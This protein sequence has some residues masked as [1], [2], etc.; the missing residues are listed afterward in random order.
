MDAIE[1]LE[2]LRDNCDGNTGITGLM[3]AEILTKTIVDIKEE[4]RSLR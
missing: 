3:L 1:L 2:K 4:R